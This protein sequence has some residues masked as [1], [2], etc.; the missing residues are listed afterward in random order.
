M[1]SKKDKLYGYLI[2]N[3]DTEVMDSIYDTG[4]PHFTPQYML[5]ELNIEPILFLDRYRLPTNITSKLD[6]SYGLLEVKLDSKGKAN[7]DAIMNGR[8][9]GSI[10]SSLAHTSIA[11]MQTAQN[12]DKEHISR[13]AWLDRL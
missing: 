6:S 5:E 4:L 11:D 12:S 2:I 8:V 10:S 1:Y 7:I 13:A 3:S 9:I